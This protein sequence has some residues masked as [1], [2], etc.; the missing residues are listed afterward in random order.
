MKAMYVPPHGD[1]DVVTMFGV[2]FFA[3][4]EKDVSGLDS[5][6]IKKLRSNPHFVVTEGDKKK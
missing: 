1:S 2:K 3:G 5:R 6:A 4:Q